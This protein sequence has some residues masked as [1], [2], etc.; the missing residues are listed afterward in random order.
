VA[1]PL[2]IRNP[3]LVLQPLDA[4]GA[5]QGTPVDVSSDVRTCEIAPDQSIDSVSTFVGTFTTMAD[6]KFTCTVEGILSVDS[7]T[8]WPD[9]VGQPVKVQL[10]DR[11][12]SV[13]YREFESEIPFDPSLFGTDDAEGQVREWS[14]E[15]P[16]LS[17]PAWNT[18]P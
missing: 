9:L 16:V 17:E 6:T 5:A 10:Y 12:D 15:L 7:R 14:M 1:K 2:I 8:L 11:T 4:A 18:T 3:K 13:D